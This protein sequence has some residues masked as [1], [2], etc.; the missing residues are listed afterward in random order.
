MA[1]RPFVT[2]SRS[3]AHGSRV[4]MCIALPK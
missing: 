3:R 4:S 1:T 2:L